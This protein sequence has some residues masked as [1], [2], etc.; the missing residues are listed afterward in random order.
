MLDF[1]RMFKIKLTLPWTVF[2]ILLMSAAVICIW[3]VL[4]GKKI[5]QYL[6]NYKCHKV[7]QDHSEKL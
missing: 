3:K 4:H 2:E 1:E 6:Q 7:D 5:V